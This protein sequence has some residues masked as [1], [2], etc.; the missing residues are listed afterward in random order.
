MLEVYDNDDI[1]ALQSLR[2]R[3][4]TLKREPGL[5]KNLHSRERF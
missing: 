2:F 3:P 4:P 1:I 5:F